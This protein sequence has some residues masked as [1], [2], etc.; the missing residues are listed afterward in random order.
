MIAVTL[1]IE[2]LLMNGIGIFIRKSGISNQEFSNKLTTMILKICIPCLIFNSIS[3]STEFSIET[4]SNCAII[5]VLATAAVLLSLGIGQIFYL[6]N[7]GS[8]MGRVFRYGLG[9]CNFSFMGI[10]VIEA[11]FGTMGTFYYSFF[12]IPVRIVYYTMSEPLMTPKELKHGKQQPL[13][14]TL[15]DIF[16]NPCLVAFVIGLIF[17]VAGWHLPTPINNCIKNVG[18]ISSPLALLLCGMVI[19]E[20]NFKRLLHVKY[21]FLPLL[22]TIAMPAL[23]FC[24]SKLLLVIGVDELLCKM[25]VIYSAFPVASLL[26]IYAVR[27]DPEPENH[28][29]AAASCIIS[30]LLCAITIPIWY[31]FL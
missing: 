12:L 30:V 7:K 9:L 6:L 25:L 18:A 10:P 13:S 20:H 19:G 3:N 29:S 17:W 21:L 27:F 31:M 5:V 1:A 26:P 2:L 14:K 24:I 28:L 8:G 16:L 15:K 22:R 4:L 11:L 23:F